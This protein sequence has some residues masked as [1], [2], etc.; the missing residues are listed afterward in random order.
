MGVAAVLVMLP[1]S[2]EQTFVPTTHVNPTWNLDSIG[3]A[4]LEKMFENGGLWRTDDG[5]CLY[6][7]L[8]Y[9][10]KGLG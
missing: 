10:P 6:Y 1:R 4:V 9:E 8:I 5:A 3:Q 2:P 7:T